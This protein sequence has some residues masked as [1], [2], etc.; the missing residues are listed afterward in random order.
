MRA[1]EERSASQP[2]LRG[3][4]RRRWPLLL[5]RPDG[6]AGGEHFNGRGLVNEGGDP[7]D[8]LAVRTESR[9]RLIALLEDLNPPVLDGP[10]DRERWFPRGS[11]AEE[12]RSPIGSRLQEDIDDMP[13][14]GV[15]Y[16]CNMD[17][18]S[19]RLPCL[20]RPG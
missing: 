18:G 20:R 4:S 5:G 8:A 1:N 10:R 17:P 9:I 13:H 16:A 12:G 3:G 15:M 6:E 14:P 2:E 19:R 11:I 7:P